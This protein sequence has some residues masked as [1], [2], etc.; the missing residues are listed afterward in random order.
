MP[1]VHDEAVDLDHPGDRVRVHLAGQCPM[2]IELPNLEH[3]ADG[4]RFALA[5][6]FA[7]PERLVDGRQ[8]HVRLVTA[9]VKKVDPANRADDPTGPGL[10][11]A[12]KQGGRAFAGQ[13]LSQTATQNG[14]LFVEPLPAELVDHC[15]N[16]F[17]N[18]ADFHRTLARCFALCHVFPV[19]VLVRESMSMVGVF[20]VSVTDQLT[21]GES[22]GR[23]GATLFQFS[24]DR[25][26]LFRRLIVGHPPSLLQ[27]ADRLFTIAY[28]HQPVELHLPSGIDPR[29]GGVEPFYTDLPV[30]DATGQNPP[31]VVRVVS[32][33]VLD[34]FIDHGVDVV[35][36]ELV[37]E[38]WI[39]GFDRF[40]DVAVAVSGMSNSDTFV[41]CC[42]GEE[43]RNVRCLG[44]WNF[45]GVAKKTFRHLLHDL[46]HFARLSSH[47]LTFLISLVA[48]LG[49]KASGSNGPR[50]SSISSCCS[51]FG[52]AM[53]AR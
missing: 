46:G 35:R 30:R 40:P 37:P 1:G 6:A 25:C 45:T 17:K 36:L 9:V 41:P 44:R 10:R 20:Y 42:I 15:D 23:N 29:S 31:L 8:L 22:L 33:L 16:Q 4:L 49:S 11:L 27:E 48:F 12:T 5:G 39:L 21:E 13:L 26:H 19:L 43:K 52:S 53:A 2:M 3:G 34:K 24:G 38:F 18:R 28:P 50:H 32:L 14:I 47:G 51:W 7:D